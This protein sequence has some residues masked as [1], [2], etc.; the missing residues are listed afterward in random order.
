MAQWDNATYLPAALRPETLQLTQDAVARLQDE[1]GLTLNQAHS[2]T[3]ALSSAK[4]ARGPEA[5]SAAMQRVVAVL[6]AAHEAGAKL[7]PE[8]VKSVEEASTLGL[9][10]DRLAAILAPMPSM[11]GQATGQ[12]NA[13]ASSMAGV[14]S[15]VEALLSSLSAI[16]GG[17]VS[18]ASKR[19]ELTALQAGKSVKQAA[20][21]RERYDFEQRMTAQ[22]NSAN[23][24]G[25]V[26]GWL[27]AQA[28]AMQRYQF[29]EGLSLDAQLDSS[30]EAARKRDT[31]SAG[32]GGARSA[33]LKAESA[34]IIELNAQMQTRIASM[35]RENA[36]LQL[37]ATGQ[38]KTKDGAELMAAA[39]VANG[40]TLDAATAS[41][42]RLYEAQVKLQERLEAQVSNTT[43]ESM[44]RL[45]DSAAQT[46]QDSLQNVFMTG[47]FNFSGMV[48][49][50]RGALAET[51]AQQ[52]SQMIIQFLTGI[53]G[54]M[55]GGGGGLLG[56]VGSIFG[57]SEGGYSDR[58]GMTKHMVSPAAF[59][60]A[61]QYKSGTPNTSGI[62][63]ILH[64]NEAVVPLTRGR[65]IPVDASGLQI[66]RGGDVVSI[67]PT[68]GDINVTVQSSGDLSDPKESA[69][70]ATHLAE[71][72]KLKIQEQLAE[73]GSY[74]GILNPRGGR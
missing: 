9:T 12:T 71:L 48:D 17:V 24:K 7:P 1:F 21:D 55:G 47:D 39:M 70:V 16:S 14:R 5:T 58:P 11:I 13:W 23:A 15:E 33:A 42:V 4:L 63:A 66:G 50:L 10:A 74:G 67:A 56:F 20:I 29:N 60:N 45:G 51:L 2:L 57:F 18:N 73:Q 35:G 27:E 64:P 28:V 30:R 43:A 44:K 69:Q 72:V 31:A 32:G 52:T 46:L 65:K 49:S 6:L 41:T 37:L 53:A 34:S 19:A 3:E 38:A 36:A 61:P 68:W 59:H 54:G 25:G 26:A 62:P 40:G 8:L 22:T